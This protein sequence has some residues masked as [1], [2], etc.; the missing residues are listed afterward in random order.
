MESVTAEVDGLMS[1]GACQTYSCAFFF[2]KGLYQCIDG[3]ESQASLYHRTAW[4]ESWTYF[5]I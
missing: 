1:V 3:T 2:P 5:F 4:V